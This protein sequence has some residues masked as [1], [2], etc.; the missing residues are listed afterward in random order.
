MISL[1]LL[2]L[3]ILYF[4]VRE[5]SSIL[6]LRLAYWN[7]YWAYAEWAIILGMSVHCVLKDSGYPKLI[8]MVEY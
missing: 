4:C 7:T 2:V 6:H 1:G 3:F 8:T 5:A